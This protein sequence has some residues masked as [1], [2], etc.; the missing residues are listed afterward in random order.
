VGAGQP[1]DLQVSGRELEGVHFAMD[2]LT[3]SNKTVSG[4]S[5]EGDPISA[6]GKTVLVIGGGDTGADCVGTSIRQGALKV[7]Q[8]E[9]LPKPREWNES[10][11]PQWP[12]WPA[13]LR[14]SSSHE[15]GCE[16]QWSI[17]TKRFGGRDGA[18]EEGDFVRV[19]WE[20]QSDG[21]PPKMFELEGSEFSMKLD[22]VVLAMGFVHAEHGRLL[23]SLGVTFDE[24][25]NIATNG[26]YMTGAA[27]VFAAGDADIGASLAVRAIFH[28]REAAKAIGEYLSTTP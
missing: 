26:N 2:F 27:G 9:I 21:N 15:E 12:Y 6:K 5:F 28:G 17:L 8:F 20:A 25:G 4:E 19:R 16:R 11:N 13:I 22:L 24:R 1:R 10:F 14:S 7:H 3:Q 18:V 23:E